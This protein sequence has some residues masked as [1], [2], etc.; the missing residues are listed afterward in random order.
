ME[1]QSDPGSE[2]VIELSADC[3]GLLPGE[4]GEAAGEGSQ[5]C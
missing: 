2:D 3:W 1:M 5:G 4:G